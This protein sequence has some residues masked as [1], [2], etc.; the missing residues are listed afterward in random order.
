MS[1]PAGTVTVKINADTSGFD[2]AIAGLKPSNYQIRLAALDRA[3]NRDA[4]L[5]GATDVLKTAH[6][7]ERYLRGDSSTDA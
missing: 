3:L 6:R 4:L 2:E 1:N 5:N 7:F